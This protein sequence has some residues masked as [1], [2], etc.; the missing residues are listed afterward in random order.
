VLADQDVEHHERCGCDGRAAGG[1]HGG[2]VDAA[3]QRAEVEPA[4]GAD[5]QLA[6]EDG[7][8][9]ELLDEG[10]GDLGEV[11]GEG[12]LLSGLQDGV[13]VVDECDAPVS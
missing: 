10:G 2:G 3:L 7:P 11:A 5:D 9:G 8:V 1:V 4:A 6:V 13:A 12:T